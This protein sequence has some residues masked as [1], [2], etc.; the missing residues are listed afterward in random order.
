M[1]NYSKYSLATAEVPP[2]VQG[3][4]DIETGISFVLHKVFAC[5]LIKTVR[6]SQLILRGTCGYV[7]T[8]SHENPFTPWW[9]CRKSQWLST[10]LEFILCSP[11]VQN[12]IRIRSIIVE[13]FHYKT[14]QRLMSQ[15]KLSEGTVGSPDWTPCM[16][17]QYSWKFMVIVEIFPSRP[18]WRTDRLT[19]PSLEPC[20]VLC[21]ISFKR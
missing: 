18:K 3:I 8:E 5:W 17:V 14:K 1:G 6:L 16:S 21:Y 11:S 19:L 10:V 7:S 12:L 9:R 13:M 2:G 15:D 20:C 4:T